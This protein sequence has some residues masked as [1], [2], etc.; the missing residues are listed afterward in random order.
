MNLSFIYPRWQLNAGSVLQWLYPIAAVGALFTLWLARRHIGR[1]PATAAFFFVGT[2]FPVLGFTNAYGMFYSFVWDHWVYLSS[3]GLIA[4]A[5][6]LIAR[7]SEHFKIRAGLPGFAAV[8]LPVFMVLTW[9]HAETYT[10]SETLWRDT[11]AKNPNAFLAHNQL[12]NAL[13]VAGRLDE[14]IEHFQRAVQIKPISDH[15]DNLG[16]AFYLQRKPEEAI[17]QFEQARRID[18]NDSIAEVNWGRALELS[19]RRNEAIGHYEQALRISPDSPVL[20]LNLGRA[21]SR[22][23]RLKEAIAH[24]ERALQLSPN[25]TEAR[26]VL[27]QLRAGQ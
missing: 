12:G 23:G 21:L 25:Y 4:L 18:P 11:L 8:I 5:A 22:A 6:A 24:C 16:A 14:A 2:L 10:N 9:R 27:T 26:N 15:Y 20:E 19:G 13:M 1:G 17:Q 7:L 3:L